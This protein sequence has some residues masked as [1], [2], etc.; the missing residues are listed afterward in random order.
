MKEPNFEF[1]VVNYDFNKRK[2]EMFNIFRNIHVYDECLKAVKKHLRNKKKFPFEDFVEEVRK[3]I[4]WQEWSRV[5]YECSVGDPFPDSLDKLQKVDC[6]WQALPNIKLIAEMLI[7]RYK[8][9]ERG[10]KNE[11]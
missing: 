11:M 2:C 8:E 9:F 7:L 3:T 6:Y 4:M 1:Y 10:N 5:E